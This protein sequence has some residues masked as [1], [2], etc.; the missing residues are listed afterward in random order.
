MPLTSFLRQLGNNNH[1]EE[2]DLLYIVNHDCG[3]DT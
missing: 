2:N 3:N 1:I